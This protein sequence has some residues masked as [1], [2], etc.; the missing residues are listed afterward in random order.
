MIQLQ[1]YFRNSVK[2]LI[3]SKT[4]KTSDSQIKADHPDVSENQYSVLYMLN[5]HYQHIGCSSQEEA[6]SVQATMMTDECRIPVGIYN[7]KTDTFEWEMIREYFQSQD[8]ASERKESLEEVLT[9]SRT[10]RR[11][12]SSWEPGYLQRPGLFA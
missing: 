8:S 7:A 1:R 5:G 12:D 9:I 2:G 6:Q 11:R 3:S 10:L 4:C